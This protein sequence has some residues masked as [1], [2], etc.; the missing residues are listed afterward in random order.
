MQL[1]H[2]IP[3]RMR[4]I[5]PNHAPFLVRHLCNPLQ[6]KRL[7][8]IIMHAA[9]QDQ[10]HLVSVFF[11]G[12]DDVVFFDDGGVGAGRD[13]DEGVVGGVVVEVEVGF[14]CV[15]I[16]LRAKRETAR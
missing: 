12:G 15:L 2:H 7:P 9:N 8:R 3:H 11:D 6:I 14:D 13:R 10:R 5:K 1:Q 16:K 4:K